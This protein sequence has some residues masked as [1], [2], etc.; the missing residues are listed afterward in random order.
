M[1]LPQQK[2]VLVGVSDPTR[3]GHVRCQIRPQQDFT[4]HDVT[5]IGSAPGT[6][7]HSIRFDDDF[8]WKHEIGVAATVFDPESFL[9]GLVKG[10]KVRGGLDIVVKATVPKRTARLHRLTQLRLLGWLFRLVLPRQFAA[11]VFTAT[12][13]GLKPDPS[14][15]VE[16][17][18]NRKRACGGGLPITQAEWVEMAA[19]DEDEQARVERQ[20]QEACRIADALLEK[21]DNQNE[22]KED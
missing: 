19:E 6:L 9:R 3:D 1:S 10:C 4:A 13:I 17:C 18:P 14:C 22:E 11:P 8:A 21:H 12:F 16:D 7:I 15:L 2:T 20:A 5:F